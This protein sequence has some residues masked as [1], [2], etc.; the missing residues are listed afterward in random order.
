MKPSLRLA[1]ALIVLTVVLS[2]GATALLILSP[3]ASAAANRR[4]APAPTTSRVGGSCPRRLPRPL[5]LRAQDSPSA[6]SAP[7][8][9]ERSPRS[10]SFS[11]AC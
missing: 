2:L 1:L 8:P 11:A 4:P 5:R 7:R 6:R 3:L 10:P 9:L